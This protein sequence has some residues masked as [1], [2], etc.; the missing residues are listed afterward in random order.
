METY[1]RREAEKQKAL[2]AKGV[3]ETGGQ[4]YESGKIEEVAHFYSLIDQAE[5]GKVLVKSEFVTQEN[6]KQYEDKIKNNIHYIKGDI[7]KGNDFI[8][9]G[10]RKSGWIKPIRIDD[11]RKKIKGNYLFGVNF[12]RKN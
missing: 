4:Y 2:L 5:K 11:P 8:L 6:Y 12:D 1:W 3:V 7:R 9:K 10:T